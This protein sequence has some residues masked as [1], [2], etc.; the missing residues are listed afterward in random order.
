[1]RHY[2]QLSVEQRYQIYAL[3][4]AGFHQSKIAVELKVD[5]S[6]S[7]REFKRNVGE[8]GWRPTQ[9]QEKSTARRLA[10]QNASKFSSQDWAQ[11][12]ELITHSST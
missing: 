11:V 6:T 8:R 2:T 3:K 12:D 5:K 9:A 4:K 7:S 1:M 10:C